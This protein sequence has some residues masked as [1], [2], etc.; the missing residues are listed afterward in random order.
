[1]KIHK[2]ENV[3]HAEE[4]GGWALSAVGPRKWF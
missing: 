4:Y 1:M 3:I 2:N